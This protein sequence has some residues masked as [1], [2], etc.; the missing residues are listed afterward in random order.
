MIKRSNIEWKKF[1]DK[2]ERVFG[3]SFVQA[4]DLYFHVCKEVDFGE[5]EEINDIEALKKLQAL[6]DM[7]GELF[8]ITD[9]CYYTKSGPFLVEAS[10]LE[11]FVETFYQTYREDFY[12]TDIVIISFE[13]KRIWV[14]F[15]EGKCWLSES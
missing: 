5:N 13:D 15:H 7:K 2:M 4:D 9:F 11:D 3:R 12:A 14:L 10:Q 8:V 6:H 1:H